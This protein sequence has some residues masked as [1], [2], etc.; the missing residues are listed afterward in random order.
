MV[1]RG[2]HCAPA[3]LGLL[4]PA[5]RAWVLVR[6]ALVS[7]W[8]SSP[9]SLP[10]R[11]YVTMRFALHECVLPRLP[12]TTVPTC[13]PHLMLVPFVQPLTSVAHI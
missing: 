2:R 5:L 11:A 9:I 13:F 1:F 7:F 12:A 3:T 8:L 4:S 10:I 6:M